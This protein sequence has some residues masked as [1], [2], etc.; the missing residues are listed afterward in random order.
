M[1]VISTKFYFDTSGNGSFFACSTTL[2]SANWISVLVVVADSPAVEP[3]KP[4]INSIAA[5]N[6]DSILHFGNKEDNISA[7]G[8]SKTG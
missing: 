7:V 2:F 1:Q 3:F 6:T 5:P 8:F 4:F